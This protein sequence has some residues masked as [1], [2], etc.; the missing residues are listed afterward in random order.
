M[1]LEVI[2]PY[3]IQWTNQQNN[4]SFN[5]S[6][7]YCKK[8]EQRIVTCEVCRNLDNDINRKY[9]ENTEV[10][11]HNITKLSRLLQNNM[12]WLRKPCKVVTTKEYQTNRWQKTIM[13][14]LDVKRAF[15]TAWLNV[16]RNKCRMRIPEQVVPRLSGL[17]NGRT[18]QVRHRSHLPNVLQLK[19]GNPRESIRSDNTVRWRHSGFRSWGQYLSTMS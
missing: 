13:A 17:L 7:T 11:T 3:T 1:P 19:A 16:P 14:T 4:R 12:N 2:S 5:L 9:D 10:V 18:S 15:D 6:I 8:K